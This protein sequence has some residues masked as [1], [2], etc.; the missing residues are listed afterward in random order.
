MMVVLMQAW[1]QCRSQ[2]ATDVESH[3]MLEMPN[4]LGSP[5]LPKTNHCYDYSID[6]HSSHFLHLHMVK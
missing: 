2:F 6:K 1:G 5:L 4:F 3:L